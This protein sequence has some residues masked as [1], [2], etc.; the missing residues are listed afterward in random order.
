MCV[1]VC[2]LVRPLL[3]TVI[4]CS[5]LQVMRTCQEMGIKSV[6]VYSDAD[7]QAVSPVEDLHNIDCRDSSIEICNRASFIFYL[8]R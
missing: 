6:A 5:S 3:S 1:C 8:F 2:D 4:A 7:N